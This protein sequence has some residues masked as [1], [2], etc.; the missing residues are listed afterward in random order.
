MTVGEIQNIRVSAKDFVLRYVRYI[1]LF[2]VSIGLG[3]FIAFLYLRYT[4]PFYNA[5]ATLLI[6]TSAAQTGSNEELDNMFFNSARANVSNEVELLKSLN[7]AKRVAVSLNLQ[8]KYYTIGNVKTSLIYPESPLQLDIIKLKDSANPIGF[9]IYVHNDQEFSFNN[10]ESAKQSFGQPFEN[11]QGTFRITKDDSLPLNLQYREYILTWE[12]IQNAAFFVL[13]GL[14]VSPVR[15]QSNILLL[16]YLTPQPLLGKD[17]LNQ[18]MEEYKKL[19]VEDKRQMASQTISFIDERL[20]IITKELGDVEKDLQK[21]KQGK[22][23]TNLESQSQLFVANKST[24]EADISNQEVRRSILKYLQEYI[25]DQKNQFT[26]VPTTLGI[27]E[28]TLLEQV[29]KYNQLQLEREGQLRTTTANNPSIKGIEIQ[30]QKLRS[31]LLEN[32]KNL[33]QVAALELDGLKRRAEQFNSSIAG[34]PIREKE[35]LEI[36]RQQGIKQTL[37]LFLF[38]TREETL[39]SQAATVSNS[40]V[41]DEA[42]ASGVPVTPKPLNVKIM[43]VFL[44]LLLPVG[45]IYLRELLNDKITT[46]ADINKVTKVPIFGEIGHAE[47]KNALLVQKNKRDVVTE[48]FRMI[49]T[50]LRYLVNN[51]DRPV[52]LV[53]S[54]F[55]GEGKSFISVNTAAVMA[56][57]GKKTVVMEFDIRKPKI[58]TALGL[59]KTQGITNYLVSNIPLQS[60]PVQVPGVE[61]LYVIACGA[62]PPNPSE[63]LLNPKLSELFKYV[64]DNFDIVIVDTP[65]VGLVSDAYTL[66]QHVDASLYIVRMGYTLKKQMHFIEELYSNNKLPNI[67]LLVNDIKASSHYYS[68]GNYGGYGYGYGQSQGYFES[69][70]KVK[71]SFIR[72]I[73]QSIRK[74]LG[75]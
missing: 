14:G 51:V 3:L 15:D 18:L 22:G 33:L 7:L 69:D 40:Q 56:L 19:N 53:T 30:T 28:P 24:I 12:P 31:D 65:P 20:K 5:R 45:F 8:K 64:R 13:G 50:N 49:R 23:I 25:A 74:R 36:S 32:L 47:T 75:R 6:K 67:G 39:I 41:V 72:R 9:N 35:L 55:S 42:I 62:I 44:G 68:Y 73:F 54:T 46:R 26:A 70:S 58:M 29:G 2:I 71:G 1:P 63:I 43:A 52:L 37:Y 17:I 10:A 34:V 61:N 16:T 60:L 4:V 38:Q 48:Q 11:G 21:Y 27:N 66:S 57:A 59:P